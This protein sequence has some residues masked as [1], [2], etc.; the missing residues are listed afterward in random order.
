MIAFGWLYW[1]AYQLASIPVV[2]LGVPVVAV[3]AATRS[4]RR[5]PSRLPMFR[6]RTVIAWRYEPLTLPW[7]NDEDGVIGPDWHLPGRDERWR[8]FVWSAIRNSGYG[9]RLL[10]RALRTLTDD[11]VTR[12]LGPFLLSTSGDLQCVHLRTGRRTLHIGWRV[13]TDSRAGDRAWPTLSWK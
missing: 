5:R 12:E 13:W 9:L 3:L 2:I 4:W 1:L 8:A 10:P 7:G 11:A 6:D